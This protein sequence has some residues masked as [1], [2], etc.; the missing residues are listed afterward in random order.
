VQ[1]L[2]GEAERV[3]PAETL[4]CLVQFYREKGALERRHEAVARTVGQ[5]DRNNAYQYIIAREQQHLSWV[6]DAIGETGT[7]VTDLPPVENLSRQKQDEDALAVVAADARAL[8][9][10]VAGW[11]D[12]V[13]RMTNARH[14]LMLQL[15]LGES[16]E[17]TRLLRQAAEGRID[18]LGRRT[19]GERT[20]GSVLSTRWVE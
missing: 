20:A 2:Q 1:D 12:R 6:A 7:T 19:G 18:L 3:T 8:E 13:T 11:R 14:R 16:L 9:S 17:H 5:Y 10:L 15:V 4:E